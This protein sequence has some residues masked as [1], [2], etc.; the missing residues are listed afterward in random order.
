M[1]TYGASRDGDGRFTAGQGGN[2]PPSADLSYVTDTTASH[3]TQPLDMCDLV[4]HVGVRA[5]SR[6]DIEIRSIICTNAIESM[7]SRFRR[8]VNARGHFP[9]EQA[10]LKVLC[11][12][13]ISLDAPDEAD[14]T[15]PTAR[16]R[17]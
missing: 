2:R 14:N 12:T 17:Y 13:V 15:G 10:A 1:V 9:N 5:V 3:P 8:A 4:S 7:N 6:L 11:L 16:K